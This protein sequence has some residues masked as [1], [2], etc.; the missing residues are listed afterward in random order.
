MPWL[1]INCKNSNLNPPDGAIKRNPP[2]Q[3]E[4]QRHGYG[5]C[6]WPIRVN[7][8][9]LILLSFT[10]RPEE[11]RSFCWPLRTNKQFSNN[12]VFMTIRCTQVWYW[13]TL[14]LIAWWKCSMKFELT[15]TRNCFDWLELNFQGLPIVSYRV[16]LLESKGSQ[17]N[18]STDGLTSKIFSGY[19]RTGISVIVFTLR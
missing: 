11:C 7:I 1:R 18:H 17:S 13:D 2:N 14:S 5:G 6:H 19:W 12:V 9:F 16:P 15:D 3:T 4:D 8:Y 10:R